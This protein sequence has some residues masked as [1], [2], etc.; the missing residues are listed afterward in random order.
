[1]LTNKRENNGLN[2]LIDSNA[3]IEYLNGMNDV[4]KNIEEYNLNKRCQNID[5]FW[6]YDFWYT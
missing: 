3:F 5:C 6:W 2:H 1:M 4:Y